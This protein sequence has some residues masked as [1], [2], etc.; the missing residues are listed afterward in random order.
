MFSNPQLKDCG[1]VNLKELRCLQPN[2]LYTNGS[3]GRRRIA[4][5]VDSALLEMFAGRKLYC[6]NERKRRGDWHINSGFDEDV[7]RPC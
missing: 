3:G 2:Y 1:H 5:G 7:Q 4:A 6:S